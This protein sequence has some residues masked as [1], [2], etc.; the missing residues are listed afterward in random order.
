ML[1]TALW[2]VHLN[3][4]RNIVSGSPL[5]MPVVTLDKAVIGLLRAIHLLAIAS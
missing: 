5:Q 1:P 2:D 4:G 3:I